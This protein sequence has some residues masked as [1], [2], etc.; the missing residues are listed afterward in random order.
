MYLT[1]QKNKQIWNKFDKYFLLFANIDF[2]VYMKL[3]V[4]VNFI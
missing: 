4:S 3:L 2:Q 1:P